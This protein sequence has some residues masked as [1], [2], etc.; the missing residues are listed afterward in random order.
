M[1]TL[2]SIIR[3]VFDLFNY[4]FR[5]PTDETNLLAIGRMLSNQQNLMNSED[6]NDYE[7]KI[8]SQWGDDGIIQYLIKN[9]SIKNET[10]IEFGVQD[11]ME[12]NT[13]FLMMNNNWSGFVMDGSKELLNRLENQK[14][15]WKYCLSHKAVWIH[16]DNIN[17]LIAS[18][19]F[20][21]IGIL[22]I[23]IDGNDY[24]ILKEID[25][26]RL[27]PSIIIMEYN[28]VFGEERKIT[29]PYDKEFHRTEAHYSNLFFGA[30]LAALND[31]AVKR[32]YD[33]VSCN[34]AGNNAY[35]VRNDLLNSRVKKLSVSKAFKKSKFRESRNLDSTLSLLSDDD[36][37]EVIKG[38]EVLNIE[39]DQLECL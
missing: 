18:T 4:S 37:L 17:E 9:L 21:D 20:A 5:P 25:M 27:N 34:K 11:Y 8:F 23:D 22:H 2:K 19:N 16:K 12:S 33:L 30:S 31:L 7:F 28:S 35:F 1:R 15:Y 36:R 13:R 6:I 3:K 29:I 14:W 24:H 26:S 39:T 38:L 32:G 10:F